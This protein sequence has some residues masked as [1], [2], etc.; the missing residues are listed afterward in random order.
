MTYDDRCESNI[1]LC[2]ATKV[3]IQDEQNDLIILSLLL[4][5]GKNRATLATMCNT[6]AQMHPN[7]QPRLKPIY[8]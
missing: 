3:I 8:T 7:L 4:T 5:E 6:S 2:V 1:K